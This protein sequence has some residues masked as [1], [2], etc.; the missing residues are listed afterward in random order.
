MARSET[1]CEYMASKNSRVY[2]TTPWSLEQ[3]G[4]QWVGLA[5]RPLWYPCIADRIL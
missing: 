2:L 5:L 4:N 1:I 3:P